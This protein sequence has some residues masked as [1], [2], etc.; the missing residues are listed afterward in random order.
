MN[1]STAVRTIAIR[2]FVALLAAFG[3]GTIFLIIQRLQQPDLDQVMRPAFVLLAFYAVAMVAFNITF[4]GLIEVWNRNRPASLLRLVPQALGAFLLSA[5]LSTWIG[6]HLILLVYPEVDVLGFSQYVM[7]SFYSLM[8]GVPV[9]LYLV[10][11]EYWQKALQ[12]IREK[13]LAEERL[14]KELLSARLQ[15]LQAQTNPHFLFNTLNSIAALISTDPGQAEATVE[16]LA[17]LFRYAMDRHDGRF[18]SLAEEVDVV[19]DYLAIE[20]VRFDSRLDCKVK[21]DPS[22][23][24]CRIP[25]LLL[26]PLVENAIKHG[27]A[28]REEETRVEVRAEPASDHQLRLVVRNQGPAPAPEDLRKGVGLA[29]LRSRCQALFGE[30]FSFRL[31]QETPGWTEAV[32]EIPRE[33]PK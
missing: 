28:R 8:F 13:E 32:L 4:F 19:K 7:V 27:V 17:G 16:R 31:T 22:V 6:G 23:L 15:A 29:N 26:Q 1:P 10:V 25:P 3:F 20:K 24:Q 9:F 18:A 21:I 14:E 11:R 2:V 5:V 30:G 33:E 12:R